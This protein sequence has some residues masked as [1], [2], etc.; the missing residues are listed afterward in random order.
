MKILQNANR[1]AKLPP[2]DPDYNYL[3]DPAREVSTPKG[4]EL[5]K[6]YEKK[7]QQ[8]TPRGRRPDQQN[9]NPSPKSQQEPSQ[10]NSKGEG[11]PKKELRFADTLTNIEQNT[12][13]RG[14]KNIKEVLENPI[15]IKVKV[16]LET[17]QRSCILDEKTIIP[18]IKHVPDQ[19]PLRG[20]FRG[21]RGF[22]GRGRGRGSFRGKRE[23]VKKPVNQDNSEDASEQVNQTKEEES[24]VNEEEDT[25]NN[26]NCEV[27]TNEA[28]DAN[29]TGHSITITSSNFQ[30]GEV[31]RDVLV[32]TEKNNSAEPQ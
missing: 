1:K 12:K 23:Y 6:Q 3:K 4:E 26:D 24:E 27:G 13:Q 29:L 7:R 8:T 21:G 32:N 18:D 28:F 16:S 30:E 2:P 25:I 20:G 14:K 11:T 10:E 19:K 5:K 15:N 17:G 9:N 31:R 22:R